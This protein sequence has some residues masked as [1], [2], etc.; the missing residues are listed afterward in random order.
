MLARNLTG[1][2]PDPAGHRAN[3]FHLCKASRKVQTS[4]SASL[5]RFC[6]V[7]FDQLSTGSCVGQATA[8]GVYIALRASGIDVPELFAPLSSYTP[9]RAIDRSPDC[10]GQLPP[11]RDEGAEPNQAMRA[12]TEW[13]L[14][15]M[16][17]W[18][19]VETGT[20]EYDAALLRQVN[21]EPAFDQIQGSALCK[22]VGQY[23]IYS[24]GQARVLD[25]RKA[26]D[27]GCPVVL[28]CTAGCDE[29]GGYTGGVLS[30]PKS[31]R[32]DHYVVID[33][34][35]TLEDGTTVFEGQNSWGPGWGESGCFRADEAWLQTATDLYALSV[36]KR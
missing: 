24:T 27:S 10:S 29:F 26:I 16:H 31:P 33:G 32:T 18:M 2:R 12:L 15:Y 7:I 28:A 4:P 5:R 20:P 9:A 25:V 19:D 14:G 11:L 36:H 34:Y 6:R 8:K 30:A 1:Y 17:T 35:T 22:L 13:G 23:K 3:G 21:M